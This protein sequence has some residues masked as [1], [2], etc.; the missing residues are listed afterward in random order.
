MQ[1]CGI[2]A[3]IYLLTFL[4]LARIYKKHSVRE[5][6]ERQNYSEVVS[7]GRKEFM[8]WLLI[9]I[10]ALVIGPSD[11]FASDRLSFEINGGRSFVLWAED[12]FDNWDDGWMIGAGLSYAVIP[13]MQIVVN[14]S[15]HRFP[16]DG[17]EFRSR[18]RPCIVGY[19]RI[20]EGDHTA[21]YEVS[22]GIRLPLSDARYSGLLSLRGGVQFYR[23]GEARWTSWIEPYSD[24][25]HTDQ[26]HTHV[27]DNTGISDTKG[28]MSI[29][30][31]FKFPL[32]R[33]FSVRIESAFT[34]TCHDNHQIVPI[35]ATF[36]FL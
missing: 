19:R 33:H 11:S 29:G 34:L 6:T 27:F 8:K 30:L 16:F 13:E 4:C 20:I 15:Y 7:R 24:Q 1:E 5:S 3:A 10:V 14:G 9:A 21:M 18:P 22:A 25:V 26:A 36:Q 23:I 35:S 12:V 17:S 2:N 28:F 31:G 32:N